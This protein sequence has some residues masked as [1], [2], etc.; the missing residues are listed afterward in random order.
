MLNI[1]WL[2]L[3]LISIGFAI[4]HGT[5]PQ[6]VNAVTDSAKL[7]FQ[8]ALGLTGILAF[9]LGLMNI[10]EKA[11]LVRFFAKLIKPLMT[12]IFPEVPAEHPAMGAMILNMASNMLGLNNAATPFGLRAMEE[13]EKLNPYPG[14]ASNAMCTFL[15]INTSSVQ[16]IPTTTIAFLAAGGAKN[17]TD[18]ILSAFLAT[19]CSTLA[20][21][22]AVKWLQRRKCFAIQANHDHKQGNS[23]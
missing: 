19:T 17:P 13:L 7:A 11:G 12:R 9:W 23:S 1:I 10:A 14:I 15:A 18:I 22:I 21:L 8:I 20:A 6:V 4:I 3:I 16:I 2:G 5:I